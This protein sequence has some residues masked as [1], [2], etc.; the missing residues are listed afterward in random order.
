MELYLL[1]VKGVVDYDS[2]EAKLVRAENETR[3]RIVANENHA[4]EGKIWTDKELVT[5]ELVPREGP[6]CTILDSYNMET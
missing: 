5:C 6:E 4:F 2:Y 1:K 3:A